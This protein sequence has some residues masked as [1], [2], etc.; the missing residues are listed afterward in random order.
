MTKAFDYNINKLVYKLKSGWVFDLQLRGNVTVVD[1]DSGTGKTYLVNELDACKQDSYPKY[2]LSDVTLFTRNFVLPKDIK[3]L[4]I[5]DRGDLLLNPDLCAEINQY[6]NMH[7]LVFLRAPYGLGL[8]PN[9]YGE[10]KRNG[11]I[12]NIEYAF[13]EEAWF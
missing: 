11:S 2:D 6:Q 13:S 9:Y 3:G 7:F 12:I 5:I 1:G 4:T 8:S 10:F